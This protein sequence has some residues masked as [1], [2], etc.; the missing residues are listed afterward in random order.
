MIIN[1][2]QI[3]NDSPTYFI[4][5]IGANHDGD[6]SRAKDLIWKAKESGADCAK[7]QHFLAEKIV[8]DY[9]F[10]GA[11][12]K[13]SHQASWKDSV[14]NIYKK[15]HTPRQWTDELIK[16]C[17]EAKIEFMTTPYDLEAVEIFKDHVNCFKIGSG[18]I[19]YKDIILKLAET[20]KPLI[21]ATGASSLKDVKDLVK[22]LDLKKTDICLMQCNTN[23]TGTNENINF[24]NLNVLKTYKK[25]FPDVVLGLSDHTFGFISVLGAIALGAKIIEKHFTDDNSRV[26]PDHHF[27]MNPYTWIEM[28]ERSRELESIMGLE[29]KKVEKNEDET[30]IVQRRSIRAS[31]SLKKGDKINYNDLDFLRPC[32]KNALTPM[33]YENLLGK[34]LKNNKK[35]GEEFYWED[36]ET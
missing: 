21:V 14:F 5:D 36:I 7:F 18:D 12:T 1:N 19:T 13:I 32:P 8:S 25:E 15:Y 31:R 29:I 10:S 28:V 4:A 9:G 17:A 22:L 2:F 27:A 11:D 33:E 34:K 6:L 3:N 20:N 16:T 23:Y 30:V 35:F 26:G 24:Q